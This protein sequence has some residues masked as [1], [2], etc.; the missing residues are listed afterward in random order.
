MLVWCCFLTPSCPLGPTNH[1]K[2]TPRGREFTFITLH[3]VR[4]RSSPSWGSPLPTVGWPHLGESRFSWLVHRE[5]TRVVFHPPPLTSKSPSPGGHPHHPR[6]M[7]QDALED[8]AHF[9]CLLRTSSS[10]SAEPRGGGS[11]KR[12]TLSRVLAP[13]PLSDAAREDTGILCSLERLA[14]SH[15]PLCSYPGWPAGGLKQ[16]RQIF[17]DRG[18]ALSLE[19]PW[20]V[21][22]CTGGETGGS[23]WGRDCPELHTCGEALRVGDPN[24]ALVKFKG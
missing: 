2:S 16:G 22:A 9:V 24:P 5:P 13:M 20:Q 18:N 1:D 23:G 8:P 14:R 10:L 17:A 11:P 15:S 12:D 3:T 4:G 7:A 21:S 19:T 6:H